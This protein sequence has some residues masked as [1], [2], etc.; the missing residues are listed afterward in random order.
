MEEARAAKLIGSSLE[1][2]VLDE[3]PDRV[4]GAVAGMEDPDDYFIVSQ[5][6]I[7]PAGKAAG[8]TELEELYRKYPGDGF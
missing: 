5:V 3:A 2:K 8:E 6:D 4:A 7:K 1:A